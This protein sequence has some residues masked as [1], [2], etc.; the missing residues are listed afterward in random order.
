MEIKFSEENLIK[1]EEI[2]KH[3]PVPSAALLPALWLA[4]KQFG[5]I[6]I[7]IMKY[8]GQLLDIPYEQVYGVLRF[9]TMLNSQ[10]KGRYHLEVC[11]NISCML[12]GGYNIL[13]YISEKLHIES[14]E[15]TDDG[16][17]TLDEV[18]CLGSCGTAPVMQ[19]NEDYKENLDKDKI[20]NLL[21]LLST[22]K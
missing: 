11:T 21:H 8:L 16:L 19:L 4:Q 7:D 18:E 13:K 6:S 5:W 20:D 3:Y 1:L 14:G 22:R 17:F 12:R 2:K 9:Y 15:T 10:P